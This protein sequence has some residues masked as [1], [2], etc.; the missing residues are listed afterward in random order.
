MAKITPFLWFDD[1]LEEAMN[2]YVSIFKNSK[3]VSVQRMGNVG[4]G[5]GTV[6]TATFELDGQRYMGL[7]GGPRFKFTEAVSMFVDCESQEEVDY[8]W[9]KLTAGGSESRCGWLKDK[10]GL[11]WQIVPRELGRW[12]GDK[13][14]VK[15]KRAMEAM[16]KMQKIDVA[17]VR[18]ASEG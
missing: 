2:F 1:N 14:P 10:F 8:F 7:Q 13:D 9:E 12:L 17:E 15:A 5:K 4:P 18:R 3:I 16:L 11:S 6:V